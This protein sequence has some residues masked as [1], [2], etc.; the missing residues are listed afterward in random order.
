[1]CGFALYHWHAT[2][3]S[4]PPHHDNAGI[5]STAREATEANR[6]W[7][8]ACGVNVSDGVDVF[9]ILSYMDRQ[10]IQHH[11]VVLCIFSCAHGRNYRDDS[12]ERH[13]LMKKW[14]W[15]EGLFRSAAF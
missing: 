4:W 7:L 10:R 13:D 3:I 2:D 1:M 11:E 14:H 5:V 8:E 12:T 6:I 15:N 9:D